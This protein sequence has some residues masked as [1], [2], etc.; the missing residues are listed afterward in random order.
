MSNTT[1]PNPSADLAAHAM[2]PLRLEVQLCF[3]LYSASHRMTRLYR[4]LLEPLGLTYPQYL[5][6]IALWEDSPQSM[7]Q[8]GGR[9]RLDSGTL[10]PLFD[11][12]EA[13]GLVSRT[14]DPGDERR[15]IVSLTPAGSALKSEAAKVPSQ[16]FH[17]LPL[18]FEELVGLKRELDRLIDGLA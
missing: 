2:D 15:V 1:A 6:M 16:V 12:L 9:L 11:R 3:A 17:Q 14:R 4:P 7:G 18:P 8:L 10:A 13:R 5:A